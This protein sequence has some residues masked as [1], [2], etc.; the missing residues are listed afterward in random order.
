MDRWIHLH[1]GKHELCQVTTDCAG[2]AGFQIWSYR[3]DFVSWEQLAARQKQ[4]APYRVGVL[5]AC[6]ACLQALLCEMLRCDESAAL[7]LINVL[8]EHPGKRSAL[9]YRYSDALDKHK[10]AFVHRP[11]VQGCIRELADKFI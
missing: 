10:L 8:T 1:L 11:T 2:I 9:S 3:E 6:E 7:S 4:D 5:L